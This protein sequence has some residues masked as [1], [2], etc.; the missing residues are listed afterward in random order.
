M[1][2]K[3]PIRRRVFAAFA[4]LSGVVLLVFEL[5]KPAETPA[6]RWFWLAVGVLV[7][8]LGVAELMRRS[9]TGA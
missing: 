2:P 3:R 7:V 4:I 6:E 8:V 5:P 9:D 1:E